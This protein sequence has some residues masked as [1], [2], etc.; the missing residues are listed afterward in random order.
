MPRMA[1][2]GVTKS[3]ILASLKSGFTSSAVVRVSRELRL[4]PLPLRLTL[5][6][7]PP[8]ALSH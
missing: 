4:H 8:P 5:A 6:K 2:P 7:T 3:G 1:A